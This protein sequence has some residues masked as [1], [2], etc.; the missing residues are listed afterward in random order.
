MKDGKLHNKAVAWT[1]SVSKYGARSA[2]ILALATVRLQNGAQI[3]KLTMLSIKVLNGLIAECP[4]PS[5]IAGGKPT[6]RAK[7]FMCW[8]SHR[9]GRFLLWIWGV[10][11]FQSGGDDLANGEFYHNETADRR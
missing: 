10:I 5:V 1:Q 8:R 7:R 6:G 4:A 2:T 9:S 11:Y 3:S